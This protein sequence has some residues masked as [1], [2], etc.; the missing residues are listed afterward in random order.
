MGT[1]VITAD[2]R[3]LGQGTGVR[4][5]G[6]RIAQLPLSSV[7]GLREDRRAGEAA[8][9]YFMKRDFCSSVCRRPCCMMGKAVR[10]SPQPVCAQSPLS[11]SRATWGRGAPQ[12]P[13]GHVWRHFWLSPLG[14]EGATGISWAGSRDAAIHP[15]VHRTVPATEKYRT[16]VSAMPRLRDPAGGIV[17]NVMRASSDGEETHSGLEGV[18][19]GREPGSE[20]CLPGQASAPHEA[21]MASSAKWD[22]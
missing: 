19:R 17:S 12:G 21:S 4:H 11:R 7:L 22:Q 15:A 13:L 14:E 16:R 10:V 3:L 20:P 8:S 9:K 18:S 1:Q 5:T 2:R 6:R